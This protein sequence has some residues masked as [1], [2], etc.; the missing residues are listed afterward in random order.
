MPAAVTAAVQSTRLG[1]G[2]TVTLP[3]AEDYY[4]VNTTTSAL[5][6]VG[7]FP[8]TKPADCGAVGSASDKPGDYIRVT[9]SFV[10]TPLFPAVSVA[11]LLTT[12]IVRTAWMRLG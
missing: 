3:P 12:P 8:T 11:A 1:T 4:C 2:V 5:V 6:T 7:S 10:F 9:A